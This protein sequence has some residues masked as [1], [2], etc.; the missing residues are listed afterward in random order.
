MSEATSPV[1]PRF[2]PR[3]GDTMTCPDGFRYTVERVVVDTSALERSDVVCSMP[4][5]GTSTWPL[6]LWSAD[7]HGRYVWARP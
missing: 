5:G 2:Y 3:T 6:W 7:G 1:G 4:T